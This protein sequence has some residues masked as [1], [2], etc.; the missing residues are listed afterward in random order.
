[1]TNYFLERE[2]DVIRHFKFSKEA[3]PFNIIHLKVSLL[4]TA[5]TAQSVALRLPWL[6]RSF[7]KSEKITLMMASAL[8]RHNA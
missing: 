2:A 5:S 1:M 7:V 8:W 3:L 6:C 4:I